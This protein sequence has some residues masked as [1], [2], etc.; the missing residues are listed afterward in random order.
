ML[1]LPKGEVFLVPWTEDWLKEFLLEKGRIQ[2]KIGKYIL[3]IHHIGS[4]AVEG[5]SAKPII[6]IAVE[7]K[8]FNDGK[9]CVSLLESLG[10]SYKGTNIL[11]DRHYFNKGEP[12]THQIH[13]YQSGNRFLME[14]LKFRDYL[15]NNDK[16]RM[17]YQELKMNLSKANK[18]DKHKYADEKTDFVKSILEKI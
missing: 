18:N 11:P 9:H 3:A 13:M 10:Y 16:A 7:I 15:R 6:D 14:Q 17:E 1:G 8:E 2:E 12:R 4:T 5:L